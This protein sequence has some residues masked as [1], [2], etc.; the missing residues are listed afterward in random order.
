MRA[1]AS[2][3]RTRPWR[4]NGRFE[5]SGL[6]LYTIYDHPKDYPHEFVIRRWDG[7][8]NQP[9]DKGEP[10][11]RGK[12]LKSVRHKLPPGLYRLQR[13]PGDDPVIV[14]TWI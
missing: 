11:A 13:E 1:G 7:R 2:G 8:T 14:E 5:L 6:V 10:F 4:R 3:T 9:I 12:T